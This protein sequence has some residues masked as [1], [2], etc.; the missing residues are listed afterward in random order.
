MYRRIGDWLGK[1]PPR[2]AKLIP[3][4]TGPE[5]VAWVGLAAGGLAV[6]A[7]VVQLVT[8]II[9]AR[10]DGTKDGDRAESTLDVLVRG[11]D[12][13]GRLRQERVIQVKLDDRI[14]GRG[15]D[16]ALAKAV[17]KIAGPETRTIP[18]GRAKKGGAAG[19]GRKSPKSIPLKGL[20]AKKA[21][22]GTYKGTDHLAW[23]LSSGR[24]KLKS[25][26]EI[27][28]SPSGA[29]KA[30]RKHPTDGWLFWHYLNDKHDWVPLSTL[31]K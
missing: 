8:T 7:S 18:K 20:I 11:F 9:E 26:G 6:A 21:L 10:H 22:R 4:E 28:D 13:K 5:I 30:I 17:R 12:T 19:K 2:E 29:A 14:S 27:Y 3:H 15:M 23:V 16:K 31:R 24:I 1:H 25:T